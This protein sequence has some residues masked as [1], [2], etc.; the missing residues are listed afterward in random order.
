M[1]HRMH[2][3]VFEHDPG[4]NL[5]E[6][7]PEDEGWFLYCDIVD[8][9]NQKQVFL[10]QRY[11]VSE[12]K[13]TYQHTAPGSSPETVR[14]YSRWWPQ[15]ND[16][17]V[18]DKPDIKGVILKPYIIYLD[19]DTIRGTYNEGTSLWE[20]AEYE[21]NVATEDLDFVLSEDGLFTEIIFGAGPTVETATDY[22]ELKP[23]MVTWDPAGYVCPNLFFTAGFRRQA[24]DE[25][26]I[27]FVDALALV[28]DDEPNRFFGTMILFGGEP[29]AVDGEGDYTGGFEW[30]LVI[31]IMSPPFLQQAY[32]N[33][34]TDPEGTW[35]RRPWTSGD[36]QQVDAQG[37]ATQGKTYTIGVIGD[38]ICVSEDRFEGNFA[39]YRASNSSQPIVK[40][41]AVRVFNWP[42]Q[43]AI[44]MA[45]CGFP[46]VVNFVKPWIT[47]APKHVGIFNAER[48]G[49]GR[50]F[51][52]GQSLYGYRDTSDW[53]WDPDA[54]AWWP[55]TGEWWELP[56]AWGGTALVPETIDAPPL[57]PP[58]GPPG[59]WPAYPPPGWPSNLEWPPTQ[60]PPDPVHPD[61][62]RLTGGTVEVIYW[63]PDAKTSCTDEQNFVRWTVSARPCKWSPDSPHVPSFTTPFVSAVTVWQ[64][65]NI[66][67]PGALD[68]QLSGAAKSVVVAEPELGN[69]SSA[70]IDVTIENYAGVYGTHPNLS[71]REGSLCRATVGTVLS[72][73]NHQFKSFAGIVLT[74]IDADARQAQ[75]R[76]TDILGMMELAVWDRGDL[77]F[78]LWNPKEAIRCVFGLYGIPDAWLDLEDLGEYLIGD[79]LFNGQSIRSIASSIA[80]RGQRGAAIWYDM[81]AGKIKTGCRFCR[82]KRTSLDYAT[83]QDNGWNSSGCVAADLARTGTGYDAIIYVDALQDTTQMLFTEAFSGRGSRLTGNTANRVTIEGKAFDGYPLRIGMQDNPSISGVTDAGAVTPDNELYKR[84]IGWRRTQ[85]L[86]ATQDEQRGF[87]TTQK[88]GESTWDL[89]GQQLIEG[90]NTFG[91]RGVEVP[92]VVVPQNTN[93]AVGQAL[94]AVG[95]EWNRA[96]GKYFRVTGCQHSTNG[97]SVLTLREMIGRLD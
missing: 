72:D 53:A 22:D 26:M 60:D 97:R 19:T 36:L 25:K 74:E 49:P 50:C 94:L 66:T 55:A 43:C 61:E 88:L 21:F 35:V 5:Y 2:Y 13:L 46:D 68:Y 96:D 4:R 9:L 52:Y 34:P 6:I 67:S 81:I 65:T 42:G 57:W 33:G 77:N 91:D 54:P 56:D 71:L 20:D 3:G 69:D 37:A 31:P 62:A 45:P 73:G 79:W 48:I 41:G 90:L 27:A 32:Y 40:K 76:F 59:I 1:E 39:Y 47:M 7:R 80:K 38:C 82:T 18:V 89:L 83:H 86:D 78:K 92:G 10:S 15:W 8:M 93:L 29:R 24:L 70:N 87:R 63:A 14:K 11:E 30:R 64:A 28:D 12:A 16:W 75:L 85:F 58:Y 44:W 23:A 17:V 84:Y 95:G 51:T